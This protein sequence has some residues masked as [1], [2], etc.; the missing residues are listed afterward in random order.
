MKRKIVVSMALVLAMLDITVLFALARSRYFSHLAFCTIRESSFLED[1]QWD[2]AHAP[3]FFRFEPLEAVRDF[4][5]ELPADIIRMRNTDDQILAIARYADTLYAQAH[6][7]TPLVWGPPAKLL[8]Q[9]KQGAEGLHCFHRS[10][11]L[12]SFLASAGIP[13]RLWAFEGACFDGNAHT[14]TE[15]YSYGSDTWILIDSML[16]CY[17]RAGDTLLSCLEA[18]RRIL[19]GDMNGV[20]FF[21]LEGRDLPNAQN[22]IARYR[23]LMPCALQRCRNDFARM[24]AE[25]RRYGFLSFLSPLFDTSPNSMRIGLGYLFGD[26]G[27]FLHYTDRYSSHVSITAFLIKAAFFLLLIAHIVVFAARS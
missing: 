3:E 4:R 16:G 22:I 23:E 26:S 8:A 14:V 25:G 6:Q 21:N 24:F 15:A 13:S 20:S 19:T 1:F 27:V 7:T 11:I 5:Q 10:I 2:P 18:R 12:S 17:A 9:A